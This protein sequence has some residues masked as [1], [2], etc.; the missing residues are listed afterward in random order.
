MEVEGWGHKEGASPKF[1][2]INEKRLNLPKSVSSYPAFKSVTFAYT[3]IEDD[4]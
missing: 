2:V 4:L 1:P 3:P